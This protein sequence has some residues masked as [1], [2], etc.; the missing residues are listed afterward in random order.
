MAEPPSSALPR[1]NT[2][3]PRNAQ[4]SSDL[5]CTVMSVGAACNMLLSAGSMLRGMYTVGLQLQQ[6]KGGLLDPELLGF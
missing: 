1:L 5:R 4:A 2:T 3:A 6:V